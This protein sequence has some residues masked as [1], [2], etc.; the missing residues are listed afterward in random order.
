MLPALVAQARENFPRDV[1]KQ[2]TAVLLSWIN[3]AGIAGWE[4]AMVGKVERLLR[5]AA[6]AVLCVALGR[7]ATVVTQAKVAG[8][9][10]VRPATGKITP[11][12]CTRE[13]AGWLT[14]RRE[15]A[16]TELNFSPFT[17]HS[18]HRGDNGDGERSQTQ[19]PPRPPSRS[20]GLWHPAG[21][22]GFLGCSIRGCR[23][24]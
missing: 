12:A 22:R 16:K 6:V 3:L 13:G 24:A 19:V 7:G 1:N 20:P 9:D 21:V 23:F 18:W 14:R 11:G 10:G 5:V 17:P 4:P 8:P 15:D 2:R